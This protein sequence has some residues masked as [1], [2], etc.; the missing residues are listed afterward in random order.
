MT[1]THSLIAMISALALAACSSSTTISEQDLPGEAGSAGIGEG[2][3]AVN[4]GGNGGDV[5]VGGSGGN[6]VQPTGGVGNEPTGGAGGNA[7]VAGEPNLGGTSGEPNT[8]GTGNTGGTCV[9]KTCLTIA[10]ELAGGQTDP[11]PEACGLV[12]DGCGNLIDCGGCEPGSICG[13]GKSVSYDPDL[14]TGGVPHLCGGDCVF[15][16]GSEDNLRN[17]FNCSGEK[18]NLDGMVSPLDIGTWGE[19]HLSCNIDMDGLGDIACVI[20]PNA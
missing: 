3:S 8:G 7:G 4:T 2:G 14:E 17:I 10:V 15:V 13:G 11:V 18:W 9:P 6:V 20:D 19:I 16:A 5:Y 12:N 1:K